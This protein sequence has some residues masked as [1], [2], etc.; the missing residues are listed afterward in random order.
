[1]ENSLAHP[2]ASEEVAAVASAPASSGAAPSDRAARKE[3][4]PESPW[5]GSPVRARAPASPRADVARAGGVVL[6]SAARPAMSSL[7]HAAPTEPG[8]SVGRSLDRNSAAHPSP[9]TPGPAGRDEEAA[10]A[11]G[12]AAVAPAAAPRPAFHAPSIASRP[13]GGSR[14]G[15]ARTS[16]PSPRSKLSTRASASAA[17]RGPPAAPMCRASTVALSRTLTWSATVISVGA[18]TPVRACTW[19]SDAVADERSAPWTKARSDDSSRCCCW[20]CCWGPRFCSVAGTAGRPTG[21]APAYQAPSRAR[22]R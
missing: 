2:K 1:M 18:P 16:I 6:G 12:G 9:P 17:P 7:A 20:C 19:V 5:R 15:K 13:G 22:A 14:A 3:A 10:S 4:K 11:Q 8:P 21:P